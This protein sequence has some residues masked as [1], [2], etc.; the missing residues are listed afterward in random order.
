MRFIKGG[1]VNSKHPRWGSS[2]V[3]GR[4]VHD[5]PYRLRLNFCYPIKPTYYPDPDYIPDVLDYFI[6][7]NIV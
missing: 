4:L 2:I 6:V 3:R 5:V 7:K 1:V